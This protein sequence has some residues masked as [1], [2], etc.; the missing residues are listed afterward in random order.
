MTKNIYDVIIIGSGPA[1]LTAAIYCVRKGLKTLILGKEIGGQVAKTGAVENYLGFGISTGIE[2]VNQFKQHLGIFPNLI[3]LENVLVKNFIRQG[4]LF[5]LVDN[6]KKI[7][8]AKA[9]I[10]CSGRNPRLLNVAGEKKY[11]SKGVS[12]CQVCDAPLFRDKTTAVIGGGNSALEAALSLAALCPKV[13]IINLTDKLTGDKIN[14]DKIK[15]LPQIE[16]I[17]NAQTKEIFGDKFVQGLKYFDTK[18][19]QIKTL[20]VK[21]IFIEIGWEPAVDYIKLVKKNKAQEIIIDHKCQTNIK[22][23]FAAGDVTNVGYYQIIIAAG[24]G[25]KAALSA[26]EYL[27][28]QK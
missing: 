24:E 26:Y 14:Q 27:F 15:K 21:G 22:G 13:Y 19:K 6:Q 10:L 18:S 4:K 28:R 11:R 20:L 9:I 3:H 1:G 8:T 5:T 7:Y 17:N 2:L 25:A 16:I 23:I 12:Y